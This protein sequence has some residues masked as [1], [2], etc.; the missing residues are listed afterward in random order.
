MNGELNVTSRQACRGLG[1]ECSRQRKS[2]LCGPRVRNESEVS[3]QQKGQ[4]NR[5]EVSKVREVSES[6]ARSLDGFNRRARGSGLP[7]GCHVALD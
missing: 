3:E 1:P 7:S 4:C 6:R 2:D 5:R